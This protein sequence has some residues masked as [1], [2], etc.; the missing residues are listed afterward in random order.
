MMGKTPLASHPYT[1]KSNQTLNYYHQ[2]DELQWHDNIT[3]SQH[4]PHHTIPKP[5]KE[6]E[7][8]HDPSSAAIKAQ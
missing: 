7:K 1:I 8:Q 6:K 5:K 2:F 4:N 3:I